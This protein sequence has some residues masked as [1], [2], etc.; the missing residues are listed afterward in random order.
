[1]N[2]LRLI[3]RLS[4]EERIDCAE[5]AR[6]IVV[7]AVG[8]RPTR[9]QFDHDNVS[10]YPRWFTRAIGALLLALFVA[11][12][13]PSFFRLFTAGR[14]YYLHGIA[15][16]IQA[17]LVGLSTFVLAETLIIASTIAA[18]VYFS[19]RARLVF[20]IPVGMGLAMALVG[21]WYVTRPYD[22]FGWLETLVPP[23]SVLFIALIGER[24]IL[25]AIETRHSNEVAYAR[26]L[27]EFQTATSDPERHP[28]YMSAYANALR[29]R[30]MQVQSIGTGAKLRLELMQSLTTDDWRAI[31]RREMSADDWYTDQS[32]E[33]EPARAVV[34]QPA[35]AIAEQER[36][37]V[38]NPF[39]LIAQEQG[40]HEL[41]QIPVNGIST[42]V[43]GNGN[44]NGKH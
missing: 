6:S 41:I 24:L 40:D 34:E 27:S 8:N 29:Q 26:A 13:L 30:L 3:K 35:L 25:D 20:I 22:I 38:P 37:T 17:A 43:G 12:G 4:D 11:A 2:N 23:L 36:V 39:G 10:K 19:G 32:V 15:D 31:V 14:D 28:R 5:R 16:G 7:R 33:L 9:G 44:G 42:P 21:N 1:M 18:K